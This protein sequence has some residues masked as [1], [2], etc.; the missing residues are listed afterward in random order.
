VIQDSN[1]DFQINPHPDVCQICPKMM[2]I[3]Y[4]VGVSHL[5]KY[6]TYWP[7]IVREMLT[8]VQKSHILQWWR[9]WKSV[10]DQHR[11]RSPPKVNHF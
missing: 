1:P 4:L 2:W 7:F 5:V 3:H 6:G 10:Q 11:S 8:N 9:K